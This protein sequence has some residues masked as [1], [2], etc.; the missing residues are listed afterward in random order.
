M[1]KF[2]NKR[3]LCLCV[4]WKWIARHVLENQIIAE[5]WKLVDRRETFLFHPW[6][7]FSR[8]WGSRVRSGVFRASRKFVVYESC[9]AET[10]SIFSAELFSTSFSLSTSTASLLGR[11]YLCICDAFVCHHSRKTKLSILLA[12]RANKLDSTGRRA[13]FPSIQSVNMCGKST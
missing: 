5:R 8:A 3:K 9:S 13:P 10:I 4:R 2:V 6:K 11:I 1:W 12:K 7:K